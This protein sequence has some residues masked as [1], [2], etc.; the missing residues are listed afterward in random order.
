MP[1]F[2]SAFIDTAGAIGVPLVI[3]VMVNWYTLR[4]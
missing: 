4:P 3:L 1:E 2:L